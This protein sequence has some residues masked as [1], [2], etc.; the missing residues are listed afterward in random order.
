MK[1]FIDSSE[2]LKIWYCQ[3]KT[4]LY[5]FPGILALFEMSRNS[6]TKFHFYLHET[7][8]IRMCKTLKL[9]IGNEF[10]IMKMFSSKKDR[11]YSEFVF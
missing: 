3:E 11:F 5:I 1:L 6:I 7:S 10:K 4:Q 9:F 8:Y 2:I